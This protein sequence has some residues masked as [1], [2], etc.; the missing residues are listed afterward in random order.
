MHY[1]ELVR[2]RLYHDLLVASNDFTRFLRRHESRH[3]WLA[4]LANHPSGDRH[5]AVHRFVIRPQMYFHQESHRDTATKQVGG[6]RNQTRKD[7]CSSSHIFTN[8]YS[9]KKRT[10]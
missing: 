10:A 3:R 2:I 6:L 7:G 4:S 5:V 8:I 1:H 9:P